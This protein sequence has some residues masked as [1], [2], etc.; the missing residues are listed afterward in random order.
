MKCLILHN[1]E[2][3]EETYHKGK[4]EFHCMWRSRDGFAA[5]NSNMDALI[6]MLIKEIFEPNNLDL[7]RV[8]DFCNS[9]HIYEGDWQQAATVKPAVLPP[10][11]MR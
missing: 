5:W 3:S 10:N 11:L 2:I 6:K 4:V 1:E 8:I 9:F 7:I